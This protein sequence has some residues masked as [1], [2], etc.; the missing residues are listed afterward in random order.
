MII[1]VIINYKT[2][3]EVFISFENNF[4]I[5]ILVVTPITFNTGVT[6]KI[7]SIRN[8]ETRSTHVYQEKPCKTK[9]TIEKPFFIY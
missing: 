4:K 8:R 3:S 1:K 2:Q 5:I 9:F 7:G 6:G